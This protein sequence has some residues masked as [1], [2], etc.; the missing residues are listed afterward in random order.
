M[1]TEIILISVITSVLSGALSALVTVLIYRRFDRRAKSTE[2]LFTT[3]N[4]LRH[5]KEEAQ[6]ISLEAVHRTLKDAEVRKRA[7]EIRENLSQSL[8][9]LLGY[10]DNIENEVVEITDVMKE[11]LD[12]EDDESLK[13]KL[14]TYYAELLER[15]K[16]GIK[17]LKGKALEHFKEL[18]D[19]IAIF[20][21]KFF[22]YVDEYSKDK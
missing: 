3:I 19:S 18:K 10:V 8:T 16:K 12:E 7:R 2:M 6:R 15:E 9:Y 14:D 11:M 22:E 17:E 20:L 4:T 1:Q 5:T 21:D 13:E